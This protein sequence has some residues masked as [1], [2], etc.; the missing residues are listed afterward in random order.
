M[1]EVPRAQ[2][3]VAEVNH[4]NTAGGDNGGV[5][6]AVPLSISSVF[7]V[8]RFCASL[9][10]PLCV[11]KHPA[12]STSSSSSRQGVR[13]PP[14]PAGSCSP[15]WQSWVALLLSTFSQ[16]SLLMQLL[17]LHVN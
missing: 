16:R 8:C 17:P 4:R 5:T 15:L 7:N 2:L 3:P 12:S 9:S 13:K 6:Q 14:P 10:Q 11:P 1:G